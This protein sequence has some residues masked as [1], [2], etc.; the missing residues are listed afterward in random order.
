MTQCHVSSARD[1]FTWALF[2]RQYHVSHSRH[3]SSVLFTRQYHVFF[4]RD[5]VTCPVHE[6]VSRSFFLTLGSF[7][8][9]KDCFFSLPIE[10]WARSWTTDRGLKTTG[11]ILGNGFWSILTRILCTMPNLM[12][13]DIIAIYCGTK[14]TRRYNL[15]KFEVRISNFEPMDGFSNKMYFFQFYQ[16]I[17]TIWGFFCKYR[18][19]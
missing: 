7:G 18:K 11:S 19:S 13:T 17:H 10:Y 6:T 14:Y 1:S 4:P 12:I 8:L 15:L 9:L 16:K 5:T 3:T 2:T